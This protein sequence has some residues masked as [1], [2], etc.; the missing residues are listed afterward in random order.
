MQGEY[1][2]NFEVRTGRFFEQWK[3]PELSTCLGWNG[4][5]DA[6]VWDANMQGKVQLLDLDDLEVSRPGH[7]HL[8]GWRPMANATLRLRSE[9]D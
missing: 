2:W 6:S 8:Q 3:N 9:L 5:P 7:A 1:T 4:N